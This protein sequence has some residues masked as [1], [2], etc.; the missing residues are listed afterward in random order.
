[1][2]RLRVEFPKGDLTFKGR[3]GVARCAAVEI[4]SYGGPVILRPCSSRGPTPSCHVEIPRDP[5]VLRQVAEWLGKAAG[6]VEAGR[7][8]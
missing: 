1:M 8:A 6:E 4:W 5:K 7:K 3:N 2:E